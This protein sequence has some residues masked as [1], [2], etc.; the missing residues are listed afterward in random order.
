MNNASI[1]HPPNTTYNNSDSLIP[2]SPDW[3]LGGVLTSL[4]LFFSIVWWVRGLSSRVENNSNDIKAIAE[5][6]LQKRKDIAQREKEKR[7]E[8]SH[9]LREEIKQSA[10]NICHGFELFAV[11]M[12]NDLKQINTKLDLYGDQ[13]IKIENVQNIQG[14]AIEKIGNK[15]DSLRDKVSEHE[16][17]LKSIP[18]RFFNL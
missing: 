1:A 5:N 7:D 15:M 8:V 18:P 6:C 10:S 14:A 3:I 16:K 17:K 2:S 11:E 9:N 4:T 13:I 12:R